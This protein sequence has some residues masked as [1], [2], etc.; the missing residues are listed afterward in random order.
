VRPGGVLYFRFGP[1]YAADYGAHAQHALAV[2]FC[3][4][5][6]A[7][8]VLAARIDAAGRGPSPYVNR[9]TLAQ[10]RALWPAFDAQASRE[11]Y[12]EIPSVNG[13]DLVAEHPSCFVNK[14]DGFDDLLV[15]VIDIV[16]RRTG[17]P[18]R[19]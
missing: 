8:D 10:F 9:W 19:G 14:V 3:Q 4:H 7:P 16:L 15:S 1:L 12:L 6:F 13:F 11:L 17:A 18:V 2:P 5:L